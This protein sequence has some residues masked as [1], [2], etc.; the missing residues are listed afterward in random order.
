[1]PSCSLLSIR[2]T[3]AHPRKSR[4]EQGCAQLRTR[5]TVPRPH[6]AARLAVSRL[7]GKEDLLPLL[8]GATPQAVNDGLLIRPWR[9]RQQGWVG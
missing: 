4:G 6:P 1:M 3:R 5:L 2:E 8:V 9:K 7:E